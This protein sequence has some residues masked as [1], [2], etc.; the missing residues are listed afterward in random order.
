MPTEIGVLTPIAAFGSYQSKCKYFSESV[1]VVRCSD[2]KAD[3]VYKY[4]SNGYCYRG[5][6]GMEV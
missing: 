6:C 5:F 1:S 2:A 4:N 3:F